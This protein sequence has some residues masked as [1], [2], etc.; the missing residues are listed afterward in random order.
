MKELL[1]D[2]GWMRMC[3]VGWVL[4]CDAD[5]PAPADC[6]LVLTTDAGWRLYANPSAAGWAFFAD[7]AQPGAVRYERQG[8][9]AF[10][11]WVDTWPTGRP[12]TTAGAGAALPDPLVVVSE[13]ALPGWSLTVDGRPAEIEPAD[14]WLLGVRVPP[15]QTVRVDGAYRPPGLRAGA[16]VSLVSAGALGLACIGELLAA[17]LT[18]WCRAGRLQSGRPKEDCRARD[19]RRTDHHAG[20]VH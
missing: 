13:L 14:G 7:P 11:V 4:V 17:A 9:S 18:T 3:N 19:R 6:D 15:G 20:P 5:V 8:P 1:A 2:T 12:T 16:A 10:S